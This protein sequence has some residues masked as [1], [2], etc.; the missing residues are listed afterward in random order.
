MTSEYDQLK[1]YVKTRCKL[2]ISLCDGACMCSSNDKP[3]HEFSRN[4]QTEMRAL[5]AEVHNFS[6]ICED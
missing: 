2:I 6:F 1:E 5:I 4:I 3:L